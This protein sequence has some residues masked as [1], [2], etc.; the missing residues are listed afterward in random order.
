MVCVAVS[1]FGSVRSMVRREVDEHGSRALSEWV[2][3]LI[4]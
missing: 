2:V 1:D 4:Q 3:C